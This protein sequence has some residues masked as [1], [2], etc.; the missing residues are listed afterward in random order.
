[1][2]NAKKNVDFPLIPSIFC[3]K[4]WE[5]GEI[6]THY[7]TADQ[8]LSALAGSAAAQTAFVQVTFVYR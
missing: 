2:E 1:M 5:I 8:S 4:F 7:D 6:R 3:S